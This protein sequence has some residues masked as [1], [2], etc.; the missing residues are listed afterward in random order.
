MLICMRQIEENLATSGYFVRYLWT[1]GQIS[2]S[3]IFK[4]RCI[5]WITGQ[6]VQKMRNLLFFASYIASILKGLQGCFIG[7]RDIDKNMTFS[8]PGTKIGKICV[9]VLVFF[10][11]VPQIICRVKLWL[12]LWDT[13]C[14]QK[15]PLL[16]RDQPMVKTSYSLQHCSMG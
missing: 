7:C 12:L 6:N 14:G 15:W 5:G 8:W 11:W 10:R 4:W 13:T 3:Q 2:R 1:V 9:H 16:L